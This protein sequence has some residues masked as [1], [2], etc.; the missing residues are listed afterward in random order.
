MMIFLLTLACLEQ[1]SEVMLSGRVR[2]DQYEST[3]AAGVNVTSLEPELS[4]F[5]EA[6]TNDAGEFEVPVQANGVY[7]ILL[8]QEGAVTTSFSGVV[9]NSDFALDE[10][11][12]FI[13]STAEVAKTRALHEGCP[14]STLEG[15]IIEGMVRLPIISDATDDYMTAE[16]ARVIATL[17]DAVTYTPCY[18]DDDGVSLERGDRVGATGQFAIFGVSEGVISLEFQRD[19]GD[20]ALSNY[21][22][23]YMPENGFIPLFSIMIDLQ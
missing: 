14:E 2:A 8:A 20:K 7:H 18:V 17:N 13:R 5:G 15:G 6:Q 21:A 4:P 9:G 1:A 3:P 11:L 16:D 22:F 12:L 10:D 23:A 19:I